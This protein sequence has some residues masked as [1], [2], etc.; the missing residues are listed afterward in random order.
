MRTTA[1]SFFLAMLTPGELELGDLAE[2]ELD[3][4]LPPEDVDEHLEFRLVDVDL[5]DGA[6]EVGE[7]AGDDA[8]LLADVELEPGP[9][10]LALAGRAL[11]LLDAEDGLDLL[12][13]ERRG[14]GAAA[15]EPGD[16]GRVAHDPPRVVVEVEAD[17]EVARED[18]LRDDRLPAGLELD[19]VLHG[20][21]DLEDPL[22]HVHGADPAG[23][24]RLHL[25]LVAGVGVDDEPFPRPVVRARFPGPRLLLAGFS[26][27]LALLALAVFLVGLE[28]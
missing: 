28:Q 17:E 1:A 18:L 4:R 25:V 12:A 5:A 7:R 26:V 27:L 13:G 10:L 21:D 23:Q 15:D 8:D 20:D 22:L 11:L 24:V 6:V 16:P 3:G 14:L 9:G 19:D 2:L